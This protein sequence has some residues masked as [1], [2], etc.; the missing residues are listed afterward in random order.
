MYDEMD[1]HTG[2]LTPAGQNH[3]QLQRMGAYAST[4]AEIDVQIA[5]AKSYPRAMAQVTRN[6]SAWVA[7]DQETAESCIYSLKRGG[8]TIQG[9]SIRFAEI[10]AHAWGHM[11]V[12]AKIVD[13]GRDFITVRGTCHDLQ[14]NNV[15]SQDVTR[16]ITG[17]SGKRYDADLI[18]V[19]MMAAA[20]IA[21][22]DS[23]LKCIPAFIWRP[24]YQAAL[25]KITGDVKTLADRRI[26]AVGQFGLIGVTPEMVFRKLGVAGI[27]DVT[28]EHLV[29]LIG[30]FN[31]IRDTD[32]TIE[33]EFGETRITSTSL[34]GSP[35]G[36]AEDDGEDDRPAAQQE[37]RQDAPAAAAPKTEAP[38]SRGPAP[39]GT[40]SREQAQAEIARLNNPARTTAQAVPAA[41]QAPE[42]RSRTRQDKDSDAPARQEP[43]PRAAP[44]QQRAM[45][46]VTPKPQQQAAPPA[47][48]PEQLSASDEIAGAIRRYEAALETASSEAEIKR[49]AQA[50]GEAF[51]NLTEDKD[52]QVNALYD[53]SV[54]RVKREEAARQ[55]QESAAAYEAAQNGDAQDAPEPGSD[56]DADADGSE[57]Y[58]EHQTGDDVGE[59]TDEGEEEPAPPPATPIA[60][61]PRWTPEEQAAVTAAEDMRPSDPVAAALWDECCAYLGGGKT[62]QQVMDRYEELSNRGKLAQLPQDAGLNFRTARFRIKAQKA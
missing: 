46:A 24:A 32:T 45:P 53:A 36:A 7:G 5:T 9:P 23:V 12:D 59:G 30:L 61:A 48:Q 35:L 16:R 49:I 51:L 54:E 8:K 38:A 19:T 31:A 26:K 44:A 28:A 40:I 55:H 47:K 29:E 18:G 10:L 13:E 57:M 50:Y 42:R 60:G 25:T 20:S 15:W 3:G 4:R 17:S 27:N 34:G 39:S 1:G 43:A 33:A 56:L 58:G 41:V 52:E 6:I 11:R 37:Q 22:R 21:Q 14:S 62:K 2:E